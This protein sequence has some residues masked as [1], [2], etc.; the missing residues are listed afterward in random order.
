MLWSKNCIIS[1][2]LKTAPAEATETK[3][4]RFQMNN[5][6]LYVPVVTL[7]MNNNIKFL[8]KIKQGFKRTISWNKYRYEITTRPKN[9]NLDYLIDPTCRNI[10]RLFVLSF[11]SGNDDP[12]RDSLY[13]YYM[14]LK[15][16]IH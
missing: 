5:A 9:D 13:K 4:A 11:R 2:I 14:P 8:E 3:V 1:E 12:T 15:I 16:F 10:N 6:K 7:S